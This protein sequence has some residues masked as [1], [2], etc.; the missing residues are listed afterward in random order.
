MSA[1][2][3]GPQVHRRPEDPDRRRSIDLDER[4]VEV[5]RAQRIRQEHE[6]VVVERTIHQDDTVFARLA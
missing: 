5:L 3:E 1:N 6:A 4:T 2:M